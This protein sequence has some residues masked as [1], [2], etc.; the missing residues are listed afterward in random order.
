MVIF[1]KVR[2]LDRND[3]LFKD[4]GLF[5]DTTTLAPAQRAAVE[6]AIEAKSRPQRDF[7]KYRPL[8]REEVPNQSE[9][10][11]MRDAGRFDVFSLSNYFEDENGNE[12]SDREMGPVLTGDPN[13]ILVPSGLDKHDIDFML[14]EPKPLPIAEITLST[15]NL[16]LLGYF[17]RDAQELGKSAFLKNGPGRISWSGSLRS[18]GKEPVLETPVTD[19]ELRS[20]VTIFRRLFMTN[21]ESNFVKAA[22]VFGNA[23]GDHPYANWVIGVRDAYKAKLERTSDFRPFVPQGQCT[24]TRKRLLDV[25]IYTQ[26]AH[27]PTADRQ[28]QF[29]K[30]LDQVKGKKSLL[31]FMFLTEIWQAGLE[32]NS[33]GRVI[34]GWFGHYCEHHQVTPD[35]HNSLLQDHPGIGSLEKDEDRKKRLFREK[36]EGLAM[37]LWQAEGRPEGGPMQFLHVAQKQLRT[38]ME[39]GESDG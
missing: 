38:A 13:T 5:L 11:M 16:R 7:L 29:G 39:G 10:G 33:A 26:Y 4:R 21:E 30:C 37:E 17:V 23:I 15:D 8:F 25:F 19:D 22:T 36:S 9:K 1:W 28:R 18:P 14:S 12:L 6:L 35:V 34:A 20:Y 32:M 31:T 2:Y 3:K 27:Q 24:F